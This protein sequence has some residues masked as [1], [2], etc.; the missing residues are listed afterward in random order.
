MIFLLFL[1]LAF[2]PE[3]YPLKKES[4]QT[5]TKIKIKSLKKPAKK[6]ILNRAIKSAQNS[7][8]NPVSKNFLPELAT[9]EKAKA[10]SRGRQRLVLSK[11]QFLKEV[12][13]TSPHVEKLEHSV[14]RAK[15]KILQM[16][17]SL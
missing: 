14:E 15:A 3:V 8:L 5:K 9:G 7:A 12:L 2:S 11:K 17:Y 16:T 4:A 13:A 10:L 6:T 1:T